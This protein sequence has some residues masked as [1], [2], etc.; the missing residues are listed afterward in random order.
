MSNL[1]N[2]CTELKEVNDAAHSVK[3]LNEEI[4]IRT[5]NLQNKGLQNADIEDLEIII[6]L[7]TC[8]LKI[9]QRNLNSGSAL[10]SV[11]REYKIR[12]KQDLLET[13]MSDLLEKKMEEERRKRR[14][15]LLIHRDHFNRL[16]ES[17]KNNTNN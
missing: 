17:E 12:E 1:S 10:S 6:A 14:H 3:I 11:E 8:A 5:T 13:Y 4:E 15:Q 9:L 16:I 7:E 2:I